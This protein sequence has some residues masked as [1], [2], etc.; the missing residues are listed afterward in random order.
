MDEIEANE[1]ESTYFSLPEGD[2]TNLDPKVRA[3]LASLYLS[4]AAVL[5]T[6]GASDSDLT[7]RAVPPLGGPT[8]LAE[9][10]PP[11]KLALRLYEVAS[12]IVAASAGEEHDL[13]QMISTLRTALAVAWD[14]YGTQTAEKVTVAQHMRELK[15]RIVEFERELTALREQSKGQA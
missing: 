6:S 4:I 3:N 8:G 15:E 9:V 5:A 7:P 12:D 11:G 2:W 1:V 10:L 13:R 14:F